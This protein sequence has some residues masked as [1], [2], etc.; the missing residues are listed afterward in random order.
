[1]VLLAI[2]VCLIYLLILFGPIVFLLWP[3]PFDSDDD[4]ETD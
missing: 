3:V 2:V 1:M 4:D